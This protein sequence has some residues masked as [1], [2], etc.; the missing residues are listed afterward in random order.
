MEPTYWGMERY[1]RFRENDSDKSELYELS[2]FFVKDLGISRRRLAERIRNIE[3]GSPGH[4]VAKRQ[5]N[6]GRCFWYIRE[7]QKENI[8][9]SAP[10]K[11]KKFI[12][13]NRTTYEHIIPFVEESGIKYTTLLARIQ[14]QEPDSEDYIDAKQFTCGLKKRWYVSINEKE[15][16]AKTNNCIV[17][18]NIPEFRTYKRE[19]Y[20]ILSK[21]AEDVGKT[22]RRLRSRLQLSLPDSVTYINGRKFQFGLA[23]Y[24]YINTKETEKI[25]EQ[26]N[27]SGSSKKPKKQKKMSK[28][29][30]L[31]L[32]KQRNESGIIK[33]KLK[34][35]RGKKLSLE[36]ELSLVEDQI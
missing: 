9:P 24:W 34:K 6:R 18:T 5:W 4:L 32:I 19:K 8:I 30:R 26:G 20:Q 16:I 14:S 23:E 15:N 36:E 7:D 29:K 35:K 13:D 17:V 2:H 3:P 11:P 28:T 1:R 22:K 27:L 25:R 12:K 10:V 33:I 31:D 21:F